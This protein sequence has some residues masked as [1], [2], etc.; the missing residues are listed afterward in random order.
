MDYLF[1]SPHQTGPVSVY[2]NSVTASQRHPLSLGGI[3]GHG[4][5]KLLPLALQLGTLRIFYTSE[6][7][8]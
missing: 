4:T 5:A 1:L 3:L 2:S 8:G 6:V 7:I